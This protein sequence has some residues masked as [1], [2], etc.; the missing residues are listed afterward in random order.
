M[1]RLRF[2]LFPTIQ[3]NS[4]I[5]EPAWDKERFFPSA[6]YIRVPFIGA[7]Y[8]GGGS[9]AFDSWRELEAAGEV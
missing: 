2:I 8:I 6:C 7:A 9:T 4:F 3:I 1:H 5:F